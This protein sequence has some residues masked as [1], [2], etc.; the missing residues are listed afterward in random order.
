MIKRVVKKPK[1]T[2]VEEEV[3][4]VVIVSFRGRQ[5]QRCKRLRELAN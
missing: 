2:V 4:E 3:K 5:L 1:S